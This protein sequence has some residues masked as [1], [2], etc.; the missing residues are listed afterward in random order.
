MTVSDPSIINIPK[1][2]ADYERAFIEAYRKWVYANHK[3]RYAAA[4]T[5][6]LNASVFCRGDAPSLRTFARIA[7]VRN[8]SVSELIREIEKFSSSPS[9]TFTS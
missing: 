6:G 3:T 1:Q 7:L 5:Y 4:R 2:V 8:Q 9:S